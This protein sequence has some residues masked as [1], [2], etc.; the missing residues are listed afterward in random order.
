M[1]K[2]LLFFGLAGV[3]FTQCARKCPDD[4]NLGD[5]NLQAATLSFLPDAQKVQKMTF[6][7]TNG[8]QI[9]FNNVSDGEKRFQFDIETLCERG[10]FLDKTVQT[11]YFNAQTFHYYYNADN[12]AYTLAVD[13]QPNNAGNYGKRQDTLFYESFAAWGQK[14]TTPVRVGVVSVLT[15][16]R[17]NSAKLG[18]DVWVQHNR[19]RFV[20]DTVLGGQNLSQVYVNAKDSTQTLFVFYT[21]ARGIEAF[22]TETETW[23]RKF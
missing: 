8:Q 16:E 9:T 19:H 12:G 13:I 15:D 7:N 14:L 11:A 22:T 3:L 6:T 17:G 10:D 20:G 23:L 1:K 18:V 5:L 2:H 4:I 21:K